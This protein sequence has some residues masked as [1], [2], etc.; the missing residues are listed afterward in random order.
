MNLTILQ[1]KQSFFNKINSLVK[2]KASVKIATYNVW[3][4]VLDDGRYTNDW[5]GKYKNEVG[6]LFDNLAMNKCNVIVKV[7]VPRSGKCELYDLIG[8]SSVE[9][10]EL[11]FDSNLCAL[12]KKDTK[13]DARF[14]HMQARWNKFKF[15]KLTNN[16]TKLILISPSHYIIG[17]RNLADSEDKDLSFYG[18]DKEMYEKLLS[19]F[20]KLE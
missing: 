20:E 9:D 14:E 6:M 5:G 16:H 19:I 11:P 10:G 18:N 12:A 15:E 2:S 3:A 17:G 7:G 13:W 1:T 8:L 4:G